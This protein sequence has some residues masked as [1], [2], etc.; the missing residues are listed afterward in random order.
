MTLD[1]TDVEVESEED[2]RE[3]A[4]STFQFGREGPR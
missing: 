2:T 1:D 3:E 4:L